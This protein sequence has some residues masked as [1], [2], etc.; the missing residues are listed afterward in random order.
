M[1]PLT[2]PRLA[3]A[4]CGLL[5]AGRSPCPA[6]DSSP[7]TGTASAA[8]SAPLE[9]A[10]A[11]APATQPEIGPRAE[12]TVQAAEERLRQLEADTSLP[13]EVRNRAVELLRQAVEQ[14]RHAEEWRAKA[15]A[16]DLASAQAPERLRALKAALDQPASAPSPEIP[17]GATV[18]QL[19]QELRKAEASLAE[20]R[21]RLSEL[22]REPQRRLDR[23]VEITALMRSIRDRLEQ[24][25][26]DLETVPTEEVPGLVAARRWQ[27]MARAEA[28]R[29]EMAAYERELASYDATLEIVAAQRDLAA[30]SVTQAERLVGFWREAVAAQRRAE[31]ERQQ[32]EAREASETAGLP[33]VQK[34][35]ER[36]LQLAETRKALTLRIEQVTRELEEVGRLLKDIRSDFESVQNRVRRGG[37][38][39]TTSLLL[40]GRRAGLP[41]L[42]R[43]RLNTA[44]IHEEMAGVQQTLMGLEEERSGLADIDGLVRRQT[45][46]LDDTYDARGHRAIAEKLRD[47]YIRQRDFLDALIVDYSGYFNRLGDLDL[48][49]RELIAAVTE[50]RNFISRTVLWTR[51]ARPFGLAHLPAAGRALIQLLQL[52]GWADAVRVLRRDAVEHPL[53][54]ALSLALVAGLFLGR[55]RMAR[56]LE[57]LGRQVERRTDASFVPT[58]QTLILTALLAAPWPLLVYLTGWR[59]DLA[60]DAS[61]FAKAVG[62]AC[63][64]V[65][66]PLALL[67][68]FRQICRRNG[69]AADH[70]GWSPQSLRLLRRHLS[71]AILVFPVSIF[72][73]QLLEVQ[74]DETAKGTLG[75][76][77]FVAA[78]AAVSVFAALV[79][80]PSR[81]VLAGPAW[82]A[83][84][85]WARRLRYPLYWTAVGLPLLVAALVLGGYYYGGL[86]LMR[87]LKATLWL[88]LVFVVVRDLARLWLRLSHRYLAVLLARR[89]REEALRAGSGETP[90]PVMS[91]SAVDLPQI[92]GRAGMLLEGLLLVGLTG[93][94]WM[95]WSDVT[96]ALRV[97]ETV[98]FWPTTTTGT[99]T[100]TRPDG[101]TVQETVVTTRMITLADVILAV[102]AALV[103]WV[104]ARDGPAFLEMSILRRFQLDAGA[105]YA[106]TTVVQYAVSAVG[107]VVVFGILGVNWSSVQWLIAAVTVGLGFG[108]QEIFANFV[109]GLILLVERPIRIGD[110]V[111]VGDISGTV[112]RIQIRATT[113]TDWDRKELIIP[114]KEFV[115]G[116]VVNWA[117]T[118]PIL[119]LTIRV[120]VAY[121]SDTDLVVRTLLAVAAG[122]PNVLKDPP[123]SA[124]FMAFGASSLDFELRAFVPRVDQLLATR[125]DLHR[126]IDRAFREAGIEIAFPQQDVHLRSI[127]DVLPITRS[128]RRPEGGATD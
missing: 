47:Q 116:K 55:R 1:H 11:E 8:V 10:A 122:H 114:N 36:N 113:I 53:A 12:V 121:G 62:S 104:A 60:G 28:A 21:A 112:T 27:A 88:V 5:L 94:L 90:A 126:E 119:R 96:P 81:G 41:D 64:E 59:L 117:L 16:F 100:V 72:V 65:A 40:R 9:T 3:L 52:Q 108:L 56:S 92:V 70:L 75:R 97:L 105:R 78:L 51:S 24:A 120:G 6:R 43:H 76:M 123:P 57:G 118:D 124:L 49:E 71:W 110:T 58:L 17:P 61:A 86:E 35:A 54:A 14:V 15:A 44:D 93:C 128:A 45:E 87:R 99:A 32:R 33:A 68:L 38:S 37:T 73:V 26:R 102:L 74:E 80:S 125:H 109:S 42:R 106:V 50:Y 91:E 30:R 85:G 66:L 31:A 22:E 111:T 29:Q 89:R 107:I 82:A 83:R 39:E 69:L 7:A 98:E 20:N 103:A 63:Q 77:A 46:R 84:G 18:G 13:Q 67:L 34:L 95:V 4:A 115:T 101:T 79:L 48:A 25:Q 127:R 23:R 19:E 2:F